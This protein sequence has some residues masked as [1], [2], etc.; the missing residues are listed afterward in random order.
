M[1]GTIKFVILRYDEPPTIFSDASAA[2]R[3]GGSQRWTFGQMMAVALLASP[4]VSLIWKFSELATKHGTSSEQDT[5][6]EHEQQS[7]RDLLTSSTSETS[8]S[9]NRPRTQDQNGH[10][11]AT[12][13]CSPETNLSKVINR[14]YYENAPW[15]W[16]CIVQSYCVLIVLAFGSFR[17]TSVGHGHTMT[18]FWIAE[19]SMLSYLL[20]G[21]P[22][23]CA[24]TMIAG[25]NLDHWYK[26]PSGWKWTLLF[27]TGICVHAVYLASH[28]FAKSWWVETTGMPSLV[29]ILLPYSLYILYFFFGCLILSILQIKSYLVNR[30]GS[31]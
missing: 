13:Y 9:Q 21:F 12:R 4:L 3:S 6:S 20:L 25:L 23:A 18:D 28:F 10:A 24:A 22:A 19:Y 2:S 16:P 15:I 11:V 1:W 8:E 27:C 14:D 5:S 30:Q 7:T 26:H 31:G 17:L 29:L